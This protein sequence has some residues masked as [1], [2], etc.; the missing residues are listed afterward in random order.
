MDRQLKAV[1][2]AGSL[3]PTSLHAAL[4]QPEVC[5]PIGKKGSLLDAWLNLLSQIEELKDI[6]VVLKATCDV[7]AALAIQSVK[8]KFKRSKQSVRMLSEPRAW[9]GAAGI[10][11]DVTGDLDAKDEVLVI[12]ALRLPPKSL[13]P[14]IKVLAKHKNDSIGGVFGVIGKDEPAGVYILKRS[15]LLDVP[16]FGY[17]DLK[18]QLLPAL[19]KSKQALTT[20][21]LGERSHPIRDRQEYLSAMRASVSDSISS[22]GDFKR[23][24]RQATVSS[25][26]ILDGLC[27]VEKGAAIGDGAVV[28][29]SV[30]LQ[31]AVIGEN[32]VISN[33]VV[34]MSVAVSPQQKV[35]NKIITEPTLTSAQ[36][37][38]ARQA[39]AG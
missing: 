34:G 13:A 23:I 20:A 28:H 26:A 39:M 12:E 2:L 3:R 25:S 32:A 37:E 14:V 38:Y 35:I 27:V 9:R 10:L 6:R 21:R 22:D 16:Q 11:S 1:L 36:S 8:P 5:L 7:E 24:S 18:E 4:G 30:I 17:F 33:S 15:A 31:G 29:N 19:S